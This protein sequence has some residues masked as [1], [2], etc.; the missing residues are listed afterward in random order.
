MPM[1]ILNT[2][3]DSR[4]YWGRKI[5]NLQTIGKISM[6]TRRGVTNATSKKVLRMNTKNTPG[7]HY[8]L[9]ESPPHTPTQPTGNGAPGTRSKYIRKGTASSTAAQFK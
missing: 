9:E 8:Q 4:G 6:M 3:V 2:P 7:N 5:R 1:G